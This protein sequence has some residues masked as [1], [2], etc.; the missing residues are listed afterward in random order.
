MSIANERVESELMPDLNLRVS[1]EIDRADW[2]QIV[3]LSK[4]REWAPRAAQA[5][6]A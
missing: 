6:E 3:E 1:D 4:T 2:D 5:E